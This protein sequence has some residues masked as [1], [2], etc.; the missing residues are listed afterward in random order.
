MHCQRILWVLKGSCREAEVSSWD[1]NPFSGQWIH[2]N[3]AELQESW[4]QGML[5]AGRTLGRTL[6]ARA[7]AGDGTEGDRAFS[8]SSRAAGFQHLRGGWDPTTQ[9]GQKSPSCWR[10]NPPCWVHSQRH[11]Q[12]PSL[13]FWHLC[14]V[15]PAEWW[16]L[17]EMSTGA[18]LGSPANHSP[19]SCKGIPHRYSKHP[20]FP[21]LGNSTWFVWD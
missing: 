5:V 8:W 4:S 1:T 15:K 14:P 6:W 10:S 19:I 13:C 21:A 12:Q 17:T 7:T 11:S 18:A 20:R 3:H 9:H 16:T 2:R